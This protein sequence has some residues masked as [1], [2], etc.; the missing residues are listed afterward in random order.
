MEYL[1]EDLEKIIGMK[2]QAPYTSKSGSTGYHNALVSGIETSESISDLDHI[3]VIIFKSSTVFLLSK[4][5]YC[6]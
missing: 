5:F 1:Q 3:K 2:C 4:Q 6:C